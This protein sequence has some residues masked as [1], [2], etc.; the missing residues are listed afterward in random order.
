ML[1]GLARRFD[2]GLQ[3]V[4][5]DAAG[6]EAALER[7]AVEIQRTLDHFDRQFRS[8]PVAR[9]LVAPTSRDN[10][11]GAFLRTRLGIE[12]QDIDLGE[13]LDFQHTPDKDTQ[14]RLFHHFGAALRYETKA[15]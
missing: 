11:V 3:R 12:A 13:V 5:S 6:A 9:L 14:W 7:V 1:E 8:I 4:A 2:I 15:L 10:A